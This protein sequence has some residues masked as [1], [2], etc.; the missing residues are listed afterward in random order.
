[1]GSFASKA[2]ESAKL[3]PTVKNGWPTWANLRLRD[4][5]LR[6]AFFKN[7]AT[8]KTVSSPTSPGMVDQFWVFWLQKKRFVGQKLQRLILVD[9]LRS[10]ATLYCVIRRCI[11]TG[12][13]RPLKT[14]CWLPS[15]SISLKCWVCIFDGSIEHT[16]WK[17]RA[18]GGRLAVAWVVI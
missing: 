9:V 7:N 1:M 10:F 13:G 6:S 12:M 5:L 2:T 15:L 8:P 4:L 16:T 11:W 3:W 14:F 17:F 18:Y